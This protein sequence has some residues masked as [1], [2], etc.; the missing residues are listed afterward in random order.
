VSAVNFPAATTALGGGS[1]VSARLGG[2]GAGRTRAV[3]TEN[4]FPSSPKADAES[5][6]TT[7]HFSTLP[8]SSAQGVYRRPLPTCGPGPHSA[9]SAADG[10][11]SHAQHPPW[12]THLDPGL[13]AVAEG[14]AGL[15]AGVGGEAVLV[16]RQRAMANC[17]RAPQLLSRAPAAGTATGTLAGS[18]QQRHTRGPAAHRLRA[19]PCAPPS[20]GAGS[21]SS[22][23]SSCASRPCCAGTGCTGLSPR[24]PAPGA[25]AL[26]VSR[27]RA[28]AALRAIPPRPRTWWK[29]HTAP[30]R[31]TTERY[32]RK[33]SEKRASPD[34][35]SGTSS[36]LQ[37]LL[38]ERRT[39]TYG[40]SGTPCT[41]VSPLGILAL[42]MVRPAIPEPRSGAGAAAAP[43][44]RATRGPQSRHVAMRHPKRARWSGQTP[45]FA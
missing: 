2:E 22:T 1:G 16:L 31:F 26:S 19:A 20:A 32:Q 21:R 33:R 35:S 14:V 7:S 15:E 36:A 29:K 43:L 23:C 39:S 4:V 34:P 27:P 28:L 37:L 30:P 13:A 9:A 41:G 12:A 25:R 42:L 18:L 6:A 17:A 40:S 24:G 5:M 10:Q 11:S 38:S 8:T 3:A 44:L 45:H